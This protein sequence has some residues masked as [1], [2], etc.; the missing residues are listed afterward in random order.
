MKKIILLSLMAVLTAQTLRYIEFAVPTFALIPKKVILIDAGH[1]GWDPG[2]IGSD[3]I[4]EKNTNLEIAAK[5][6]AMFEQSGAFVINTRVQDEA[7]GDRKRSDMASRREIANTSNADILISIHQ[8]SFQDEKVRGAQVFYYNLSEESK[9]LAE[10]IQAE[11]KG[12]VQTSNHREPKADSSYYILKETT[13][14]AVI[15]ECGFLSNPEDRLNL[16]NPEYQ[17]KIAW[18]IYLGVLRYFEVL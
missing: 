1:G 18:A 12:F 9:R 15:V 16:V 5:L 13:I 10:Y 17:E 4:L 14:P 11:I 6:Q 7:L 2:M 3:T 8:N